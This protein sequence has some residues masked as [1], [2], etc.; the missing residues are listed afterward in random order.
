MNSAELSGDGQTVH[1]SHSPPSA[2]GTPLP[3][4]PTFEGCENPT[5]EQAPFDAPGLESE[6]KG[7][8]TIP[9]GGA[10]VLG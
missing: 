5:R 7:C 10:G 3:A 6:I 4:A 2:W 8:F 1:H 9:L